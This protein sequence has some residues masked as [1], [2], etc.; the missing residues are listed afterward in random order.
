VPKVYREG[1]ISN[2]GPEAT[3]PAV[4]G[5]IRARG[6]TKL[7]GT[8]VAV[9]EV[10]LDVAPGEI[11]GYLGP[12]GAGKSTTV[13]M[14]AT[15]IRPSRGTAEVAGVPVLPEN[16]P[17]VRRRI[18]VLTE[19]PGLYLK[20][21]VHD[22]LEFFA[23]LYGYRGGAVTARITRALDAVRL[24]ERRGDL[25][26]T[27][28]KGLRQR[29]AIARTLI[30]E[31]QVLFLD[32]PTQGLDPAAS[33]E[34]RDAIEGLRERGVTVFLTTHR[35][36]EAERLCDRVAIV[37][38]S[39]LRV[40]TPGELRAAQG[41]ELEVKVAGDLRDPAGLFAGIPGAGTWTADDG[42]FRVKV[43]DPRTAAPALARAIVGAGLDLL[44]LS[45]VTPSLEQT[46][47]GLVG[48]E[49]LE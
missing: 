6:L 7:F 49:R 23:G 10:D 19:N 11:F 34:V 41:A 48:K 20:L 37:S 15:L 42:V 40:G 32:E 1:R 30:G 22:N 31:P 8:R 46:Y 38:T 45:D 44:R 35:L 2:R 14:L 18:G 25:A 21:S 33:L 47:L 12:N 13:R 28:S 3:I 36:D 24:V 17:E 43:D 27:L 16:G 9:H 29:A 26:G 5:G 39:L 4:S